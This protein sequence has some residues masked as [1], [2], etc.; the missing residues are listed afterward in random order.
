MGSKSL[1]NLVNI[2]NIK[3]AKKYNSKIMNSENI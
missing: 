1:Y 3:H 2:E